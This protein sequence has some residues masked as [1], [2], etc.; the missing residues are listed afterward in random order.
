MA[1]TKTTITPNMVLKTTEKKL[2][3]ETQADTF[4]APLTSDEAFD[5]AYAGEGQYSKNV[6]VR[7]TQSEGS[8][9]IEF[10][11]LLSLAGEGKVNGEQLLNNEEKLKNFEGRVF[12]SD[13]RHGVPFDVKGVDAWTTKD[14]I[15]MDKAQKALTVWQK[16]YFETSAWQAIVRG[17]DDKTFAKHGTK[18]PQSWHPYIY[19]M[20]AAGLSRATWSATDATYETNIST[21]LNALAAS[22]NINETRIYEVEKLMADNN[23]APVRVSYGGTGGRQTDECWLWLYPRASRIRLKT[24]LKG[25]YQAADVRGPGNR[26]INGDIMKFGKF[27]FIEASYIPRLTRVDANN[28]NLQEAWAFDATLNKRTDARTS[29]HLLHFVTG[30]DALALA[31]PGALTFDFEKSDYGYK[32]GIGSYRMYG[33]K[34]M[35]TYDSYSTVTAVLNQSSVLLAEFNG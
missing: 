35:E 1:G 13:V 12:F 29:N 6:I 16:K 28:V 33:M 19:S 11:D 3:L 30:A 18:A 4:F 26:A 32:K 34:R 25:I 21:L 5:N 15:N 7:K 8:E 2:R 23:I 24:A 27:L 14:F 22:D 31:E 20:E 9:F 17:T 10:G